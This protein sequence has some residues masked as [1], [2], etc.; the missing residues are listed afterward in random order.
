MINFFFHKKKK[1]RLT[2]QN[3][4]FP[5]LKPNLRPLSG[6]EK[7]FILKIQLT[8]I[9]FWGKIYRELPCRWNHHIIIS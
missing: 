3:V 7:L 6:I 8:R 4:R 2:S 1:F 9:V 5:I